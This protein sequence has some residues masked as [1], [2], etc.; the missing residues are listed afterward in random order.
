[1]TKLCSAGVHVPGIRMVDAA[2]GILGLEWIDGESVR[3][4]L[5]GED[6]EDEAALEE[7][8]VTVGMWIGFVGLPRILRVVRRGNEDDWA[9]AGQDAQGG[10]CARRSDDVQ[11]DVAAL[12]RH[13]RR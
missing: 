3:R 7:Y 11:Y 6:G 8:G 1:M 2:E 12:W 5:P 9:R 4:L 13:G 10:H